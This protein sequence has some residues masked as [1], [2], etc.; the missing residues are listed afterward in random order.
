MPDHRSNVA[1]KPVSWLQVQ[2]D[3]GDIGPDPVE[4]ALVELGAVCIE[5]SDAGNEPILEPDPG[6]TPLWEKVRV[7]ALFG[8]DTS[9][10][11]IRLAIAGSL[12]PD[13]MPLVRFSI[14]EDKDWIAE[15]KQ[16]LKPAVFGGALWVCPPDTACPATGGVSITMEP[17]LAF[18]TGSHPTTA[19]CLEWLA[20]QPLQQKSILDFG[21]G[22]GILGIAG[23]ALGASH[24]T[25]VDIDKQALTATLENSQR[26]RCANHLKVC[27]AELL[28]TAETFDLIVANILSGTLIALEPVLRRHSRPR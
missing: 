16:N 7:A 27:A 20:N 26:N 19:L 6:T 2:I 9:E 23:I 22:S 14:I 11:A 17:G 21:C 3:L 4:Q 28:D 1:S 18:G 24:V 10:T 13:P 5:F 12:T 15:W 8:V 25:A